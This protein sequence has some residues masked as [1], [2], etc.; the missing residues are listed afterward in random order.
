MVSGCSPEVVLKK[1]IDDWDGRV[2]G[3][4]LD[5]T[6]RRFKHARFDSLESLRRT[7]IMLKKA[8]DT[9]QN[10]PHL[11]RSSKVL[12]A[13]ADFHDSPRLRISEMG[14]W[15]ADGEDYYLELELAR[16]SSGVSNGAIDSMMY[17]FSRFVEIRDETRV[18]H[19]MSLCG[20]RA[21]REEVVL[22]S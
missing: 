16:F 6:V 5:F 19:F 7:V 14:S 2:F 8:V 17:W 10:A 21:Y 4:Y 18:Q 22:R 15:S 9:V 20:C 13:D 12:L 1:L 11:E 3:E